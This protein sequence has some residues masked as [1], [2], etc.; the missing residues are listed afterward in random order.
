VTGT[1]AITVE[2]GASYPSGTTRWWCVAMTDGD[3]V[4]VDGAAYRCDARVPQWSHELA[5]ETARM[6]RDGYARDVAWCVREGHD[7]E[8]TTHRTPSF[9]EGLRRAERELAALEEAS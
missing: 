1:P 6:I 5:V 4:T 3:S 8:D 7:P 9:A 2:P